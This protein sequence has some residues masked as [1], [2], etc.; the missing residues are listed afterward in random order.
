MAARDEPSAIS[1]RRAAALDEGG[2][3]Y[4]QRRA[5]I[6]RAAGDVFKRHGFRGTKIGDIAEAVGM[7]RATI[8]Y[9][10]GG[11]EELF[12]T[13][14][15]DAVERNCLRAEEILAAGGSP[16]EKLRTLIT[17]LMVSYADNYPY[18]YLYI[19]EDLGALAPRSQWGR[20]M[21]RY[22]K[23]YEN[24]LVAIVEDG[25][26]DGSFHASTQ[27]WVVAYGILGM[28]AWSNR[29]F[30]PE[31]STVPAAEIGAAYAHTVLGGLLH[32]R[33]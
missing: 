17:E 6:V 31:T 1:R 11:K 2:A 13:A 33:S 21:A 26:A 24:V 19:Q 10:V 5:A 23:R 20:T 16:P 25:L 27:P 8:Y 4:Q 32:T 30:N 15:G 29:W 18:L 14:V 3:A 28:V 12:H 7:D 9:Y 22:N